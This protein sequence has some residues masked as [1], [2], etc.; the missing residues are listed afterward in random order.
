MVLSLVSFLS[1][2]SYSSGK[3]LCSSA[4][5]FS[6]DTIFYN[7]AECTNSWCLC[8]DRCWCWTAILF[9][10]WNGCLRVTWSLAQWNRLYGPRLQQIGINSR[11]FESYLVKVVCCNLFNIDSMWGNCFYH[12]N[13]AYFGFCRR[14]TSTSPSQLLYALFC[15]GCMRMILTMQMRL[16][17]LDRVGM[18]C[19]AASIK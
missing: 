9:T 3:Y 1:L 10:G 13:L 2:S 5:C 4:Y 14:C 17:I 11:C 8:F 6:K 7:V 18:I 12:W 19:L 16:F 15:L